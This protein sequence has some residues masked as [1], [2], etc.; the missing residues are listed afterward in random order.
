MDYSNLTA[1][2]RGLIQ[3][4]TNG[5]AVGLITPSTSL[6]SAISNF[7]VA[8][9]TNQLARDS[10]DFV[11][12]NSTGTSASH[13]GTPLLV[14]DS[15]TRANP[16]TLTSSGRGASGRRIPSFQYVDAALAQQYGMG[17]T[18]AYQEALAN[19]A[20]QR[21]VADLQAAGLNPVLSARYGGAGTFTPSMETTGSG[22]SGG[23]GRSTKSNENVLGQVIGSL[24]TIATG[25][26]AVGNSVEKLTG[27]LTG[28]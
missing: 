13:A 4:M 9:F 23:S 14:S 6:T 1:E 16:P 25:K 26:S 19:T 10:G 18:A 17:R 8:E 27:L 11:Y 5:S 15:G 22:R 7:D 12:L 2:Q 24:V 21:E 20:H 28:A 3:S